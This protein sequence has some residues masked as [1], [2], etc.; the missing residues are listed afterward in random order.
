MQ[1]SVVASRYQQQLLTWVLTDSHPLQHSSKAIKPLGICCTYL[2]YSLLAV[3][4]Q[5]NWCMH[6]MYPLLVL[7]LLFACLL[8]HCR[9]WLQTSTS[10]T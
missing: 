10:P 9:A 8:A 4:S 3:L 5:L 2:A 7:L 6:D 1:A